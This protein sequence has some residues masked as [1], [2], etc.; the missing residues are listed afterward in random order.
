MN[1]KSI[2]E[3]NFLDARAITELKQF[4]YFWD[5]IAN[6]GNFRESKF[7]IWQQES[8]FWELYHCSNWLFKKFQRAH[9]ISLEELTK[10]LSIYLI[11]EKNILKVWKKQLKV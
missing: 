6:N 4:A 8:P 7:L 2:Q 5:R 11:E 1:T 3:N 9:S 10:E